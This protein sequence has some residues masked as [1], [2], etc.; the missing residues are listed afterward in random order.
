[1]TSCKIYNITSILIRKKVI[2]KTTNCSERPNKN[3]NRA[4]I[5]PDLSLLAPLASPSTRSLHLYSYSTSLASPLGNSF[6]NVQNTRES[7]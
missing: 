2:M 4:I 6:E 5:Q 7:F 1:M 3:V